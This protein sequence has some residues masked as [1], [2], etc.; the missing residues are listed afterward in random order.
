MREVS[1][2]LTVVFCCFTALAAACDDDDD[3]DDDTQEDANCA[4]DDGLAIDAIDPS[5]GLNLVVQSVSLA[6]GCFDG[7]TV[8][9]LV[10]GA[11]EIALDV[12]DVSRE[13]LTVEIPAGIPVG[14][15]TLTLTRGNLTAEATYYATSNI[16]V[17]GAYEGKFFVVDVSDLN[18]PQEVIADSPFNDQTRFVYDPSV[19]FDGTRVFFGDEINPSQGGIWIA[20]LVD[21]TNNERITDDSAVY[22]H[23]A[24]ASPT[25][26][27]ATFLGCTEV[28]DVCDIHVVNEDGTGQTMLASAEDTVLVNGDNTSSWGLWNPT[29]S[30]DGT[31]IAYIRDTVCEGSTEPDCEYDFY[32]VVMVMNADGS[33]PQVVHWEPGTHFYW[34]LRWTWN[35]RLIWMRS[36]TDQD[37]W[38]IVM[39]KPDGTDYFVV[40]PP[41]GTWD[42]EWNIWGTGFTWMIYSPVDDMLMLQPFD[43]ADFVYFPLTVNT[44][45]ATAGAGSL[46]DVPDPDAPGERL[47][48]YV[49]ADWFGWQP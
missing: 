29:F 9:N 26:A 44:G 5:G 28:A 13:S 46:L 41:S 6:G 24:D 10:S 19:N 22:Y 43:T 18:Q 11:E 48:H 27:V 37:P 32:S 8:A 34:G 17:T 30:P 33:N 2:W 42:T 36:E 20:D 7:T 45:S 47:S 39:M 38:E 21:A 25:E 31:Q 4:A 14:A 40:Q 16:V 35:G 12:L 15:Y 3:N 49:Q 1:V 23:S